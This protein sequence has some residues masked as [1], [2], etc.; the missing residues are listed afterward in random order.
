M[1]VKLNVPL[2][3]V[4]ELVTIGPGIIFTRT[5]PSQKVLQ[6]CR[7]S[8]DENLALKTNKAISY[9]FIFFLK[10]SSSSHRSRM[11]RSHRCKSYC[12]VHFDIQNG[13]ESKFLIGSATV[14]AETGARV[15]IP[16]VARAR[17]FLFTPPETAECRGED[18]K[19][20]RV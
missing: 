4:F 19:L 6:R 5:I 13:I 9:F 3:L 10:C 8:I 15:Q 1:E 16:A 12:S 20:G 11:S 14:N 18:P 2:D 7:N 17:F